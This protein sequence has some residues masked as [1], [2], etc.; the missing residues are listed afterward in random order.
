M[1]NII[2]KDIKDLQKENMLEYFLSVL[3]DRSISDIRDGLK[4]VQ[5]AILWD[6]YSSGYS[7]NKPHVKCAKVSGS[8]IG[9]LHPHGRQIA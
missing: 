7:S 5:R 3:Y 6:M 2:D 8:V 1:G 4:P 9:N